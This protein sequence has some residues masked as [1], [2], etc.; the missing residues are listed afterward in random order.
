MSISELF[1]NSNW[2][3]RELS[4]LHGLFF[5]GKKDIRNLML[6]YGDNSAPF[7][8]AFPSIGTKEIFYDINND[9]LIQLPISIQF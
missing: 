7:Q 6:Q 2:L 1:L 8:K 3:E 4:E 5:I 9:F